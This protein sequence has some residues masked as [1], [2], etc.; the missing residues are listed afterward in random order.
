MNVS[1]IVVFFYIVGGARISARLPPR[2]PGFDSRTRRFVS[3]QLS[4]L[5]V[6]FLLREFFSGFS[7]FVPSLKKASIFQF[8]L[9]VEH[10]NKSPWLQRQKLTR[11]SETVSSF[12]DPK[13]QPS[14]VLRT[15][16]TVSMNDRNWVSSHVVTKRLFI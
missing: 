1:F 2:C 15:N 12:L 5:L 4:L 10:L 11:V 7:G 13:E 14:R 6:L 8:D 3:V 9:D 16:S